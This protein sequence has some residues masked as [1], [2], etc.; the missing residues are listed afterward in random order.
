MPVTK[1]L[2]AG[3]IAG[4]LANGTGYLIAG[5]LFHPFQARTPSTW[6]ASESWQHYQYAILVR[7]AA[8]IGIGFFYAAAA[9]ALGTPARTG[10]GAAPASAPA[11]GP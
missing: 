5:R 4:I 11:C 7:I 9:A 2:L 8:C 10:S 6:R 1:L 3:L